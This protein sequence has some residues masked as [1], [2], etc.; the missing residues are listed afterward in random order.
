MKKLNKKQKQRLELGILITIGILCFFLWDTFVVYPIKLFVVLTHEISH[1]LAA[2]LTGGKIM[3]IQINEY[4]GGECISQGGSRLFIASAGYLGSLGFGVILFLS[5]YNKK[6]AL[7][8]CTIISVILLLFT[9]NFM[10]GG[11]GIALSMLYTVLLFLSPRFFK[12]IA[13]SYLL[14]ILGLVSILYVMIDIKEDIFTLQI[15]PSDAQM[16]ADITGIPSILYGMVWFIIT[17]AALYMLFKH[18]YKEGYK[19]AK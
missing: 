9:A 11:I 14:K 13:N 3:A 12:P 2:I 6:L 5:A 10:Y 17:G 15:E 7:W 19:K 8:S 18:A 1:G 16:L 4:L